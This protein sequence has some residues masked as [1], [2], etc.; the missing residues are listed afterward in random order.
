MRPFK[1]PHPRL[2]LSVATF[3]SFFIQSV[4][5]ETFIADSLVF[6]VLQSFLLLFYMVYILKQRQE[7][8]NI[9]LPI[10]LGVVVFHFSFLDLGN[11]TRKRRLCGDVSEAWWIRHRAPSF[12]PLSTN[13]SQIRERKEGKTIQWGVRGELV[14]MGGGRPWCSYDERWWAEGVMEAQEGKQKHFHLCCIIH[15]IKWNPP[16]VPKCRQMD[17]DCE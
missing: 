14:L 17:G 6:W 4:L 12:F 8:R 16:A 2:V 11:S 15:I 13:L 10:L 5:G 1:I 3:R 7:F 9:F